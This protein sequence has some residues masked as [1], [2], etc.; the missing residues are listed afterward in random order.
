MTCVKD[1]ETDC[2]E[3]REQTVC[4]AEDSSLVNILE[5]YVGSNE[6]EPYGMDVDMLMNSFTAKGRL[7]D[8]DQDS[9]APMP[10]NLM[11]PV[12]NMVAK[13]KVRGAGPLPPGP[14]AADRIVDIFPA[15]GL[16]ACCV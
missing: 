16:C 15:T 7:N 2:D 13:G 12:G 6:P 5:D 1:S 3:C 11:P 8:V 14:V 9:K 10:P 4:Q